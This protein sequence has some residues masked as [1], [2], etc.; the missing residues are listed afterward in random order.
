VSITEFRIPDADYWPRVREICDEYGILLIVDETVTG[1]CRS[2]KMWAIEHWNVV[3][4]VVS[5][6][7][8]FGNGF[9]VTCVAVRE[10]FKESFEKI[11]ASSSYGGNPMACAAGNAVIDARCQPDPG[12]TA[13][14]RLPSDRGFT[15]QRLA[16]GPR[17]VKTC[18]VVGAD[19]VMRP[20]DAFCRPG[21]VCADVGEAT[22]PLCVE[23][24]PPKPEC[25]TGDMFYRV[26]AGRAFALHALQQ[27]EF[28][29]LKE[30]TG[31]RC[32]P[33]PGLDPRLIDRI[34]L[35]GPLCTK[36]P[37]T[38][39][40]RRRVRN[41]N[42][43][44]RSSASRGKTS[45]AASTSIAITA[46]RVCHCFPRCSSEKIHA[47]ARTNSVN[48]VTSPATIAYGRRRPPVPPPARRIGSTGR[49]HGVK[50]VTRPATNAIGRSRTILL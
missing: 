14:A 4:D 10:P 23:A 7:K 46:I 45:V 41:A 1:C 8:G 38:S 17:C 48:V 25:L 47:P 20:N 2:G 9:P 49:M 3:P 32:E 33:I 22:G 44:S 34:P 36:P 30:G 13:D 29:S 19:G 16:R 11:S 31:G 21:H 6:G 18:G 40:T 27:P 50:T 26:Q 35:D 39:P 42:G 43:R 15:C 37:P 24:P 5:I 28:A 12:H